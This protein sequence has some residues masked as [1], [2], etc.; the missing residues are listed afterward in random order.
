MVYYNAI[1]YYNFKI[2]KFKKSIVWN[3]LENKISLP[4]RKCP[5][6]FLTKRGTSSCSHRPPCLQL[7][8][9]LDTS[10]DPRGGSH[11]RSQEPTFRSRAQRRCNRPLR[12]LGRR[13]F[14]SLQRG[15]VCM[16]IRRSRNSPLNKHDRTRRTKEPSTWNVWNPWI[17]FGGLI[18]LAQEEEVPNW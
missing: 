7:H 6:P 18:P 10:H 15:Q 1:K 17:S 4:S 8:F 9:R 3:W 12:R 2:S 13:G 11:R 16:V 5:L 14:R